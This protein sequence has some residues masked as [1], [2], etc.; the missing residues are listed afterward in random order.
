MTPTRRQAIAVGLGFVTLVPTPGDEPKPIAIDMHTHFYDPRRPQ[1]VPWPGKDDKLLYRPVLPAE[2]KKLAM[3]HGVT[4]TVVVEASPW[5]EDNHWLLDL[6]KDEAFVIGVIGR[7]LPDD[8]DFEKHLSRFARNPLFRGIRW[9][10]LEALTTLADGA[11]VA[12]LR[13]LAESD[14]TLDLN[15][16][17]ETFRVAAEIA[18]K[19]PGLRIVVN[20]VGNPLIDGKEPPEVWKK[21]VA[22]GGEA[23][24]NVWCKL[25][26]L[27]DGT[28]RREQKAPTELGF[29]R[30]V[31]DV[32]WSAFGADRLVFGSNWPVSEHY[33]AFGTVCDLAK[34]FVRAKGA[35]AVS[36]VF[37]TNARAAYKLAQK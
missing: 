2:Y 37:G 12:R 24:K 17:D 23:G 15:G 6:A 21:A 35:P 7:L 22:I 32:V 28:R 4:G 34:E 3:P 27:V 14:L 10:E 30:P 31:L 16:G 11:K 26:G 9:N 19:V 20:H 33:A 1:G 18:K 25:S 13:A 36:K 5:V 29:Y 8:A